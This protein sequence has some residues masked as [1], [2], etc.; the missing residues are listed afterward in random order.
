MEFT[1]SLRIARPRARVLELLTDPAHHAARLRGLVTHELVE[2][3]EGPVGAVSRV[4]MRAGKGTMEARETITLREPEQLADLPSDAVVRYER[5]LAAEGMWSVARERL[6]DAGD[7]TTLWVSE[8]E[9]R[10][11]ALPMRLLA[12]LM[13]DAFRKQTLARMED[14]RAFA[15]HG[16]DVREEG[17][18]PGR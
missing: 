16:T 9:Y 3:R 14:F 5:G 4:V 18:A 8:N 12:P 10:F 1:V 6:Q 13:R 11:D 17:A 2:G 7:G 15:E